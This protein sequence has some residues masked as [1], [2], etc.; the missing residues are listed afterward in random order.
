VLRDMFD[1]FN[2]HLGETEYMAGEYSV[3]DI[4]SYP[5]VHVHGKVGIGLDAWPNLARWHD[6]VAAR[7]AVARAWA[8]K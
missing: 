2:R 7:P 6:R 4:S 8:I 3:A 1:T 5:D